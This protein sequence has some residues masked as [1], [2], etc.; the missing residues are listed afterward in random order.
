MGYDHLARA[1]EQLG[2]LE[3]AE[4]LHHV[5]LALAQSSGN[6]KAE[7]RQRQRLGS[8]LTRLERWPE[9]LAELDQA[10]TL[11]VQLGLPRLSEEIHATQSEVFERLG[12]SKLALKHL[13]AQVELERKRLNEEARQRVGV[14]AAQTHAA[15]AQREAEYH[16]G[17]ARAM[18][19]LAHHDPLTGLANRAGVAA[20]LALMVAGSPDLGAEGLPFA[21]LF[22]DLDGFKAVNDTLG[23]AAGDTLLC[24]VAQKLNQVLSPGDLLGRIGGDEFTVCA[25][26]APDA[27]SAETLAHLLADALDEPFRVFEQE[28]F[29]TVSIGISLYPQGGTD[30]GTLLRHADLAMYQAK[31]SGKNAWRHYAPEM[32]DSARARLLVGNQLRAALGREE[33]R[34]HYQ[35]QV[36]PQTGLIVGMEALLRWFPDGGSLVRPDEFIPAAE[37]SGLIVPIGGWVLNAACAQV[38]LWRRSGRPAA[39][40]AVNVSPQQF[41]RTDF[42]ATVHD[43]CQRHH[44][45]AS[46][47]ELE[48]TERGIVQDPEFTA[49]QFAALRALG[50]RIALNDFGAGESNL[51]RLLRLPFDVLKLDRELVRTLGESKEAL[52]VMQAMTALARTLNLEVVAEGIET[53]AQLQAVRDL[54]CSRVQGYLLGVPLPDWSNEQVNFGA[55]TAGLYS[56]FRLVPAAR[57]QAEDLV[58][59]EGQRSLW[60]RCL[61]VQRLFQQVY[62][63]PAVL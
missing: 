49:R 60:S 6:R 46:A 43:A 42:V 47:L 4:R 5:V 41:A 29:L 37:D 22:L 27:A 44:L 59:R 45:D 9:A 8:L 10:H 51:S 26:S 12:E 28:V 11:A 55:D 35:P 23:H 1:H 56:L 61:R 33:F 40:V 31:R 7:G 58:W 21:L 54:G 24:L 30:P 2:E 50:V 25:Q 62:R 52:R 32:Q 53:P 63:L 38:A 19:H 14:L 18:A 36:D 48:L 20:H 17:Q 13:R 57:A 39:R 16:R 3:E 15:W 34:L